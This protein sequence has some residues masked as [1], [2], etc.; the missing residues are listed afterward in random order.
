MESTSNS[1]VEDTMTTLRRIFNLR[2]K[3]VNNANFHQKPTEIISI[4]NK[5]I[6]NSNNNIQVHGLRDIGAFINSNSG[7]DGAV[8]PQ[9]KGHC[10]T[11]YNMI[12]NFLNDP[13]KPQEIK[14]YAI[15]AAAKCI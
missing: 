15:I 3:T 9:L 6:N 4:F 11:L 2:K 8:L 13:Q 1:I 12:N 5:A 7:E 14:Q 10:N